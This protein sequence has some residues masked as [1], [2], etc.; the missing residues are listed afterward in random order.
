[1]PEAWLKYAALDVE[2]LVEARD[3]LEAELRDA[4]KLEWARQEFDAVAS[5]PPPKP[6]QEPWRRTSGLHRVRR[7]RQL[8]VVRALWESRNELAQRRDMTPTRVLPDAAII[9]T[10]LTLPGSAVEMRKITGFSGRTRGNDVPRY[11]AALTKA[12]ALTDAEL[13]KAGSAVDGPPPVRAWQDKDPAAAARLVVAR[14]AVAAIADA[15]R[16][17]VENLLS[18]DTLRRLCWTP[19]EDASDERIGDFLL[20]A[21]ARAWQVELTSHVIGQALRRAALKAEAEATEATEAKEATAG[22]E[23]VE[24]PS[25]GS[26]AGLSEAAE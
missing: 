20:A 18:P 22:A 2:V 19:P 21:G 3:L 17:P 11:F 24:G 15:H 13:P 25:A 5:A 12:R 16:L 1:L 6:R 23:S 4:G 10:A 9:E 8:A 7:P 14:A 26:A